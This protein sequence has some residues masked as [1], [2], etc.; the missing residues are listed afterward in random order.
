MFRLQHHRHQPHR[1]QLWHW[2][3]DCK[4]E[5]H[6]PYLGLNRFMEPWNAISW[7]DQFYFTQNKLF[8]FISW[9]LTWWFLPSKWSATLEQNSNIPYT[10][11]RLCQSTKVKK[12]DWANTFDHRKSN[13]LSNQMHLSHISLNILYMIIFKFDW[14]YRTCNFSAN[15]LCSNSEFAKQVFRKTNQLIVKTKFF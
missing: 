13:V 12:S 6:L 7:K 3:L 15:Q 8:L 10:N 9:H 14:N 4:S 2:F 5:R 1:H 11:L